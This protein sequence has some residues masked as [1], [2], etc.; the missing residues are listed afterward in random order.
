VRSAPP[1]LGFL[2][3]LALLGCPST[4]PVAA[5]GT[6][7]FCLAITGSTSVALDSTYSPAGGLRFSMDSVADTY[8]S[9]SFQAALPGTELLAITYD[10]TNGTAAGTTVQEAATGGITW[11][12]V[13][14]QGAQTGSFSLTLSDAGEA[15]V[16]DAGTLWPAPQGSLTVTLVPVGALTD[17]GIQ[18]FV[19]FN[20]AE[21]ASCVLAD[22]G[23]E[24]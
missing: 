11:T 16:L 4:K 6:A 2:V 22:G 20:P 19:F 5:A 15:V 10:D 3:S 24:P 14:A 1:L 9:L 21:P 23:N 17:A 8:P 12:Q 18:V 7:T 13:S